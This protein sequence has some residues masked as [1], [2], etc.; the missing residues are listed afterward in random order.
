MEKKR[1]IHISEVQRQLDVARIYS[2]TVNLKAYAT[3]G[4]AIEYKGWI[5][6]GGYW[7][8]GWHR[9]MNPVN[10]EIRTVP[11]IFIFEFMGKEVY[12]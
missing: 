7:T 12:L 11:D 3:D 9:I 8:G 10:G 4:T 1:V 5:V 2:Q 6:K